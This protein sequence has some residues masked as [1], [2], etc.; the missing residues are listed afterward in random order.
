MPAVCFTVRIS[1]AWFEGMAGRSCTWLWNLSIRNACRFQLSCC[2]FWPLTLYLLIPVQNVAKTQ[3]LVKASSRKAVVEAKRILRRLHIPQV[4]FLASRSESLHN[5]LGYCCEQFLKCRLAGSSWEK[6][7]TETI[8]PYIG[9]DCSFGTNTCDG[10]N[11]ESG[12]S[13]CH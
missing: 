3:P 6:E 10:C 8:W 12:K 7:E 13:F 5:F 11:C 9:Q 2:T 1:N 4:G